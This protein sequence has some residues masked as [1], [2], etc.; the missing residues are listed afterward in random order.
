MNDVVTWILNH[1]QS[2]DPVLRTIIVGVGQLLETSILVGLVVPG[3]V[4]VVVASTGIRDATEFGALIVAAIVGS[5]AGESIGFALGRFLG[6]AIRRGPLGRRIGERNWIRAERYIAKRGGIAI[7]ISRFIPVLHS[8]IPLT[9]GMSPLRYRLF[10]AW[11]TPA[12]VLWSIA[13]VTVGHVA[14]ESYRQLSQHLHWAGI[15]FAAIILAFVIIVA[16]VKK[17]LRRR[18]AKFMAE[19]T[20]STTSQK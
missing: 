10:I 14:A 3:D 2:V 6:P 17:V 4:I 9:V 18:E 15:I 11:T 19:S 8:L 5:L 1:V 16:R 12:C 7:F 13:Y 20:H